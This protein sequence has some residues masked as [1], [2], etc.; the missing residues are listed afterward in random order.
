W[1][2]VGQP[3]EA[4]VSPMPES[5]RWDLRRQKSSTNRLRLTS[6]RSEGGS[7]RLIYTNFSSA[8]QKNLVPITI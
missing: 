1:P 7:Y 2:Y 5:Q 8:C 4:A 3:D 6:P